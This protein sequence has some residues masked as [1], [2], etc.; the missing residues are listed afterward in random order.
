MVTTPEKITSPSTQLSDRPKSDR[1]AVLLMGYGEVESYEDFANYNEQALNLLTAKFAPVPT[2]IYPPLAKLLAIFDLHEW[3]HQH[4]NFI[5]PH[6]AI[7]EKQRAGIEAHLQQKWGDRVQVFK[8][9][10][11]CAP[12]LPETVLSQIKTE[13]FDK[14]L[15]YPL[16]V[17]DSIFTSGIAVEQVNN[18]LAQLADTSSHW[19]TGQR[20]I[21]S[22]YNEP[23]YIN[24]MAELV[25]AKID[26]ELAIAHLPSQ[27]GIVLMNHGC[28]H[29]AKGFTSGIDESQAL[30]EKVREQLINR[31]PLISVGWLNHDTPL[32][33]WTQPNAQ[34]AA[35]NLIELGA[36]AIVFMPIGFATENHETLLDVEHIIE[37]LRRRHPQVR[38]IKMAC[39]NDHPQFLEMAANWANPQI[40]ALLSQTAL[41]INPSLAVQS[42]PGHHSHSHHHHSHSHSH[43]HD[44]HHH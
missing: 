42:D 44:H 1:V 14:I 39:V 15:I 37:A 25:Q 2:W 3:S 40:E 23:E 41:S 32:I 9:F 31:Y 36:T 38:Y 19:V 18:A 34:L 4:G 22:F 20:Y 33:D 16:L 10:N 43:D 27:I 7:F 30:Y 26:E 8:A 6:N 21:P 28:P 12:F 29:K 24:L 5:S 13:G 17:V 35:H 11:F